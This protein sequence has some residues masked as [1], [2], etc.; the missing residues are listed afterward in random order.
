MSAY[1][2]A[3]ALASLRVIATEARATDEHSITIWRQDGTE[4]AAQT[5]R[6]VM[7]GRRAGGEVNGGTGREA[8]G[9]VVVLGPVGLDIQ[10]DD[11]FND[12]DGR[13]YRVVF[14]YPNR[15]V[16]TKADVV[17]VE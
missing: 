10:N 8:Q 17:M 7:R 13:L 15:T 12:G 4:V 3:N 11:E 1:L 2:T 6:I 16:Q 9:S 5:V 14:V